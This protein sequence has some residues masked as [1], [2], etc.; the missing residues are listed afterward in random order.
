MQAVESE[1]DDV[2]GCSADER[3]D[4]FDVFNV[5]ADSFCGCGR[6]SVAVRLGFKVIGSSIC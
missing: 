2:R 6:R 1:D 5:I 3:A 4:S